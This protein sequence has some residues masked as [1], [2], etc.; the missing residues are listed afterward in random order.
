MK[1]RYKG[2]MQI[3][4]TQLFLDSVSGKYILS[5]IEDSINVNKRRKKVGLPT[6]EEYLEFVN[7]SFNEPI[8]IHKKKNTL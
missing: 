5:P 8:K 1:F 7:S 4:G 3:Y 2:E 6:V